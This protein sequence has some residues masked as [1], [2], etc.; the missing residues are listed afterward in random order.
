MSGLAASKRLIISLFAATKAVLLCVHQV[1]FS[2]PS[3]GCET[4]PACSVAWSATAVASSPAAAGAAVAS[5]AAGAAVGWLV[6]GAAGPPHAASSSELINASTSIC[7]FMVHLLELFTIGV[8]TRDYTFV[9]VWP[10]ISYVRLG[11]LSL[12]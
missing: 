5:P 2:L 11:L 12:T 8:W 10:V 3:T 9:G 4:T 6:A 1:M 7:R